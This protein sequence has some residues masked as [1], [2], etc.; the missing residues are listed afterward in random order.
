MAALMGQ[1]MP[2]FPTLSLYASGGLGPMIV[3]G[4]LIRLG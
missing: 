4:I 1:V 2:E 3:A